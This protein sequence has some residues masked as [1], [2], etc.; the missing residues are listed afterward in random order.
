MSLPGEPARYVEKLRALQIA[1]RDHLL[2]HLRAQE[3]A[4]HAPLADVAD[5]RGGDTIYRIDAH[6]EEILFAFCDEWANESPFV[7]IAEGIEG[8]GWRV[9]PETA[10][11]EDAAFLLIVDPIDGTRN[12]MYNK[13]SAWALAGVAPN[14]GAETTL[15]D[16]EVAVMTEIPT[17]RHVLSDQLWAIRGEG[18]Y[19]EAQDLRTGER[20]PLPLRPSRTPHL[21]HGFSSVVKF[22]P[23]AKA[24][25]AA[26]E[27]ELLARVAPNE[28]ENPLVFDDEYISTGGQ[29]YEILVGH[30]RFLADLR[31]VFFDALGLPKKL[32]CHPYDICVE[33]IAREAGVILTD[34]TG[35]PLTAPLDIRA[36]VSW[37]GY[38]NPALRDL[39][40]PHL[41]E[42]LGEV[43]R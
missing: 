10:R 40:E 11:E 24:A 6:S 8:N 39:I 15:A 9:F 36:P 4:A 1:I 17:T 23:P 28:G 3:A 42:L 20:T 37:V 27:E 18:A 25:I 31:P 2:A 43:K 21:A 38:A 41:L 30:D 13:R 33:R 14:R 26:F 5:V 22:F 7:L 35:G 32:V 34:E 19:R 29:I 12:I 16:I